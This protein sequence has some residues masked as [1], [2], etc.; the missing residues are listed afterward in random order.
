MKKKSK[1]LNKRLR[2]LETAFAELKLKHGELA[3]FAV[4]VDENVENLGHRVN[5]LATPREGAVAGPLSRDLDRLREKTARW[6][7]DRRDRIAGN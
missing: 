6:R 5:D 7:R 1:K 3:C 4:S 2:R